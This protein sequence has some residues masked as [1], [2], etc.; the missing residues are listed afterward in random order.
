MDCSNCFQHVNSSAHA[1][2]VPLSILAAA[3]L[4]G[5]CFLVQIR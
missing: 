5:R 2:K 4:P 3:R 1:G